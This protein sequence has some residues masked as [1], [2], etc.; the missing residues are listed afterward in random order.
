MHWV[1]E[2]QYGIDRRVLVNDEG[3]V[4]GETWACQSRW[5]ATAEPG[6]RILGSFVTQQ[7]AEAALLRHAVAAEQKAEHARRIAEVSRNESRAVA[8]LPASVDARLCL[9][10]AEL[11]N[12]VKTLQNLIEEWGATKPTGAQ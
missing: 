2:D 3:R 8:P 12:M 1:S 4:V 7:Q 9:A 10:L 11:A 5:S 6:A